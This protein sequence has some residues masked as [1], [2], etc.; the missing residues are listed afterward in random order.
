[1]SVHM[2]KQFLEFQQSNINTH[3]VFMKI[4]E[5]LEGVVAFLKQSFSVR[6]VSGQNILYEVDQTKTIITL[7][8]LWRTISFIARHNTKP[9]ALYRGDVIPPIFAG[10]IIAIS[11]NYFDIIK[12]N[13]DEM[14]KLLEHEIASLYIPGEK[15]QGAI[16]KIRH[17]GSQEF[18]LSQID[19]PREFLLKV[20]ETLCGGG[21]YH[22]EGNKK[23]I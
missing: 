17:I 11:G 19:A 7:N 15:S 23:L 1:V 2:Y 21:I 4:A 3:E 14:P 5:N 9:Q 22:E 6:G 13:E 8:I 12:E 18:P 20:I 10:R 16:M